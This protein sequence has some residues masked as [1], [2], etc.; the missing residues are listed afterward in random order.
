MPWTKK[1]G[2]NQK[3]DE[4]MITLSE[5]PPTFDRKNESKCLRIIHGVLPNGYSNEKDWSKCAA[6]QKNAGI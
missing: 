2:N 1:D 3:K 4:I 6:T 5:I